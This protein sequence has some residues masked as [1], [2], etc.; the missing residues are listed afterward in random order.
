MHGYSAAADNEFTSVHPSAA[1][2]GAAI[3]EWGWRDESTN[4][5]SPGEAGDVLEAGANGMELSSVRMVF[6]H[7]VVERLRYMSYKRF[8]NKQK[9][10]SRILPAEILAGVK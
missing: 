9:N 6:M 5:V 7:F 2:G 8:L 3:A 4:D 1:S 10:T